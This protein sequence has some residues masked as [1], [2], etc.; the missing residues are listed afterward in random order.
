MS[1]L[2]PVRFAVSGDPR[3]LARATR[4]SWWVMRYTDG[5]VI[6]EWKRD[7]SELPLKG[8]QK[9]R[10]ACPNGQVAELGGDGDGAGRFVQLKLAQ[11]S[12]STGRAVL[13]HM[14]GYVYGTDGRMSCAVWDYRTRTLQTF[15]DN[16]YMCHW[17]GLGPLAV[18]P[19]GLTPP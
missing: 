12:T 11:A 17:E 19:L 14:V 18:D 16:A 4:R 13:A 15:A 9:V 7:W 10:L 1:V 3:A 8:R 5:T 6:P 2:D